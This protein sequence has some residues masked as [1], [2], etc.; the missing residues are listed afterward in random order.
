MMQEV[1][2][3]WLKDTQSALVENYDALGLRASGRWARS[4]AP[5]QT[6]ENNRF[7]V[8]IM[9]EKYTG[10]IEFGRRP[11]RNQTKE[12][13]QKW[14]GWAG[15]TFLADWVKAKGLR[16]S[17]Y[18]VAWKIARQGWRVPNSFNKGGLVSNVVT[19]KRINELMEEL[20]VFYL[21]E[22]RTDLVNTL[23]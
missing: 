7:L 18:A 8:G 10:A 9:G 20:R 1:I 14:V 6:R 15:S 2:D 23:K 19:D 5:Y 3:K 11:N 17:P 22:I 21:K 16:I 4:L 13:L 12:A